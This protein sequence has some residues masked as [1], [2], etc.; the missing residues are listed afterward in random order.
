MFIRMNLK[1]LS[2]NQ[3]LTNTESLVQREREILTEVLAHLREIDRRRLFSSLGFSSLFQYAVAKLQYSEDQAFRRISA[4]RMLRELPE[5]EEKLNS[6]ELSLSNVNMAQSLFKK[7]AFT[8]EKKK[9]ILLELENKSAKE[10]KKIVAS[11]LVQP[12]MNE[13][14]IVVSEEVHAKLEQLKGLLAHA[15]PGISTSELIDKLC[16]LGLEKWDPAQKNVRP[17]QVP[18]MKQGIKPRYISTSTKKELW[19]KAQSKCENCGS[20]YALEIDH[21]RP[22][23]LG[24]SSGAENLRLLCRNCNQRAAIVSFGLQ[25]M[26][27][28]L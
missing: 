10:A 14:K 22:V 8:R 25:K 23:A 21:K 15:S 16:D 7:E 12:V 17:K 20:Q 28:Y 4:M 1:N 6:G 13:V 18:V 19:Q 27:K 26:E 3:L 5:M 11:F 24:G 2:D 9:E